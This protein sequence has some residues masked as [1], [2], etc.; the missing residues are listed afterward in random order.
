MKTVGRDAR[1]RMQDRIN[2]SK[3]INGVRFA[4]YS[5]GY[6]NHKRKLGKNPNR[7]DMRDSGDMR[8]SIRVGAKTNIA[9]ILVTLHR[10]I[11]QYHQSGTAKGGKV[12]EWFGLA[13]KNESKTY[14]ELENVI[15]KQIK[16]VW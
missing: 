16:R 7:V 8:N 6:R 14:K 5:E 3:D 9:T 15:S 2:G 10:L 11:G 13:D 1:K 12:R 4:R